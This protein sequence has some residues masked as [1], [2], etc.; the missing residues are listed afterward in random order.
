MTIRDSITNLAEA[1]HILEQLESPEYLEANGISP[2]EVPELKKVA[3]ELV[4]KSQDEAKPFIEYS[5]DT[6][7]A[8]KGHLNCIVSWAS[9]DLFTF[10]SAYYYF[11]FPVQEK[12]PNEL[13]LYIALKRLRI[14]KKSKIIDDIFVRDLTW[15]NEKFWKGEEI[16][17]LDTE[18]FF[19]RIKQTTKW[20]KILD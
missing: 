8:F 14:S 9:N 3:E 7:P 13:A 17:H 5:N 15:F 4:A 11:C 18:F 10:W 19:K 2:E 12:L 6:A 16:Y 20:Y 1:M